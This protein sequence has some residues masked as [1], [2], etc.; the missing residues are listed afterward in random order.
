[1]SA[2]SVEANTLEAATVKARNTAEAMCRYYGKRY[3]ISFFHIKQAVR[4]LQPS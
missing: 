4:Q 2:G 3:R 1:V